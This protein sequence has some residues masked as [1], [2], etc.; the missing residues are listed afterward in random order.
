MTWTTIEQRYP[1]L[2]RRVTEYAAAVEN[3]EIDAGEKIRL[4]VR[5]FRSDIEAAQSPECR[6]IFDAERATKPIRFIEKYMRPSGDYERFDLMGWQCCWIAQLFGMRDRVTGERKYL[7]WLCVVGS[8]NGKSPLCAGLALYML[9]QEGIRDARVEIFA[10][11]KDQA[12]IVR[13]DAGDMVLSSPQLSAHY[14]V[15]TKGIRYDRGGT[16]VSRSNEPKTMDGIRP[17]VAIMDEIHQMRTYRLYNHVLRNLLKAGRNRLL[18]M[19]STMGTVLDGVLMDEYRH[20]DEV[21]KGIADADIAEREL[22]TVYEPDEGDDVDDPV[23]RRKANPSLGVLLRE[24]DLEREW[25]KARLI[26]AR[27]ADFLT[28]T[29]NIFTRA[30]EASY[31]SYDLLER[32]RGSVDVTQ[33]RGAE[34]YAGIDIGTTDDHCSL[35]LEIELQDGRLLFL[36]HTWVPRRKAELDEARLEYSVLEREGLLTIVDGEYVPQGVIVDK[37]DELAK[38]Y[39]IRAIGFDPANATLLVRTLESWRGEGKPPLPCEPVRQGALTLNE[40]MKHL[41]KC[42]S[43]GRVVHNRNRLFEWYLN[44]VRLRKDYKDKG[45]ENWVPCKGEEGNKI[46][47]FAAALDAHTVYLRHCHPEGAEDAPEPEI[48]FYQ[49]EF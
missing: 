1:T 20:A 23:C 26:P 49:L 6:W 40:P 19:I 30:A 32:N 36:P 33:L 10:N 24:E 14:K 12:D 18:L 11:S 25:Q 9:G 41:W 4:A 21:L 2:D 5:R 42:F 46:D 44:N 39:D 13:N 43:D 38:T 22:V 35:C 29:L 45:T 31:L 17:T 15:Q 37:L 48:V 47:G 28:K 27:K 7:K 34:A 16:I 3:G 8:G